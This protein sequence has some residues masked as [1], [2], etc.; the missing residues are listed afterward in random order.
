MT[1]KWLKNNNLLGLATINKN[2]IILNKT[3]NEHFMNVGQAII[4]INDNHDIVIKPIRLDDVEKKAYQ[5][6]LIVKI[7]PFKSY[8]RLGNTKCIAVLNEEFGGIFTKSGIQC[9]TM[10]SDDGLIVIMDD[11]EKEK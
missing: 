6:L 3:F 9:K 4:G 10:W 5:D 1:I 11:K 8:I 2:N 7:S